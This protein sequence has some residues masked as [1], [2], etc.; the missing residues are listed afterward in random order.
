MSGFVFL[1]SD[2]SKFATNSPYNSMECPSLASAS[3]C[4]R[5]SVTKLL[6]N[7]IASGLVLHRRGCWPRPWYWCHRPPQGQGGGW[8]GLLRGL[9]QV[10]RPVQLCVSPACPSCP[11]LM[12]GTCRYWWLLRYRSGVGSGLR[13]PMTELLEKHTL[14]RPTIMANV[15]GQRLRSFSQSWQSILQW[16]T[17][18]RD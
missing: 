16:R 9:R 12:G 10:L 11:S 3:G 8:M 14:V 4:R 1:K 6:S 5:T 15:V 7:S 13:N 18:I 2:S 17:R